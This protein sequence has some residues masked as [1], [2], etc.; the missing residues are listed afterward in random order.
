IARAAKLRAILL[1]HRHMDHI[2]GVGAVRERYGAPVWGHPEISDRVK[3]DKQLKG[4]ERLALEGPHPRPL[5]AYATP[6]HSRT[7][8]AFF[9]ERSRT[10]CAGDLVSTLGT[11]VINP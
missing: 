1:T 6:G 2:T 3:L 9:E 4:G 10:L 11:V 7:H 8:L 5:V